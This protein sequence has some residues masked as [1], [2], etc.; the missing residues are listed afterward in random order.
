MDCQYFFLPISSVSSSRMLRS[1]YF[2]G[3]FRSS[4]NPPVTETDAEGSLF[5]DDHLNRRLKKKI[6][7]FYNE[8]KDRQQVLQ[9]I[10]KKFLY[11]VLKY[12]IFEN[13]LRHFYGDV[14]SDIM[15]L[16]MVTASLPQ[17]WRSYT[18]TQKISLFA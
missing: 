4:L 9:I 12:K 7:F 1:E 5:R 8:L 10:F 16:K 18:E 11:V 13:F 6:R 15:G 2:R 14:T 17:P 3:F